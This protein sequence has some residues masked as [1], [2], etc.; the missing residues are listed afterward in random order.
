MVVRRKLRISALSLS[1]TVGCLT[2][3]FFG[4]VS[5]WGQNT[6]SGT[7]SGQVTDASGAAIPGAEIQLIGKATNTPRVFQTNETGRYNIFN[8][9]PGVYDVVVRKSG[10]SARRHRW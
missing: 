4:E 6:S 2:P 10:F 1:L 5:A 9:N 3:L 7:I 8:L